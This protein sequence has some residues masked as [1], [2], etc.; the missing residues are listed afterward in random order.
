MYAVY[1]L[2]SLRYSK[3][4]IGFTSNLIQRFHSHNCLGN[5]GWTIRYR[6]W[7]VIHVEIF[8]DKM[9]ALHRE[10]YLKSGPGRRF[11]KE[12]LLRS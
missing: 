9:E 4:Y 3:T 6:P 11:I 2:F 5:E 1:I 8:E 10:Q 12:N 7:K